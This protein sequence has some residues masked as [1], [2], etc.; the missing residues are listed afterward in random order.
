M[1]RVPY[2]PEQ[3]HQGDADDANLDEVAR[4]AVAALIATEDLAN[5]AWVRRVRLMWGSLAT[6]WSYVAVLLARGVDDVSVPLAAVACLLVGAF[7]G[8][9]AGL[10][11]VEWLIA[12]SMAEAARFPEAV[13]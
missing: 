9:M 6:V 4:D 2:W 8:R 1:G 3:S 5:K 10:F 13:D 7:V 11:A 12:R